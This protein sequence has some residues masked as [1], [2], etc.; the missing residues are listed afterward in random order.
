MRRHCSRRNVPIASA[1]A[2]N[3]VDAL[4]LTLW[5]CLGSVTETRRRN[6]TRQN[7]TLFRLLFAW[8]S[9]GSGFITTAP[10][11]ARVRHPLVSSVRARLF[12]GELLPKVFP[13]DCSAASAGPLRQPSLQPSHHV[14]QRI[15][16]GWHTAVLDIFE[17][18][19]MSQ[20]RWRPS[21]PLGNGVVNG[22]EPPDHRVDALFLQLHA[23]GRAARAG[24]LMP[25]APW[26]RGAPDL[27][28]QRRERLPAAT[29]A[30]A[31]TAVSW[32]PFGPRA[33][34]T[35]TAST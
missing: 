1:A 31:G 20:P 17:T 28:Q 12:G 13:P 26:R 8:H 7:T 23:P 22:L 2:S 16:L 24:R 33:N 34:A 5:S 35:A 32:R 15:A 3:N 9:R 11:R 18:R 4:T 19:A 10:Q 29:L 21:R 14:G 25:S 6:A 30:R 27:D